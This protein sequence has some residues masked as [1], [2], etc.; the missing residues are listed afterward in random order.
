[1]ER[2]ASSSRLSTLRI[3]DSRDDLTRRSSRLGWVLLRSLCRHDCA[4]INF[5]FLLLDYLAI[6]GYLLWLCAL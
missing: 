2:D 4:D 5:T 1:M 3:L 6:Y